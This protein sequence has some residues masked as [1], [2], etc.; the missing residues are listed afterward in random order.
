MS[1]RDIN[2][3]REEYNERIAICLEAGVNPK[4]A[5]EIALKESKEQWQKLKK[6]NA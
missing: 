3:I 2:D 5:E 6:E 1:A 4:I